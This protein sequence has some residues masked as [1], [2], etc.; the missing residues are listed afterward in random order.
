MR[1]PKTVKFKNG[2]REFTLLFEQLRPS[3]SLK[4]LMWLSKMLGGTAG[5][6]LGSFEGI[7][8]L[9]DVK[10]EDIKLDKIGKAIH[11]IFSR[12][13]DDEVVEKINF[14]FQSVSIGGESIDADHLMFEGDPLLILK[15]AKK[16][17]EVNFANFLEGSSGIGDKIRKTLELLK[18]IRGEQA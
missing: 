13:D 17:L 14:L 18:N 8:S 15:V 7:K 16:A 6:L 2:E 12:L 3:K 5:S 11:E 9:S 4:M 1:E 10:D